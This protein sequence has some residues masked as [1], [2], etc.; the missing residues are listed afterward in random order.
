[1]CWSLQKNKTKTQ[2]DHFAD[3]EEGGSVLTKLFAA[4]TIICSGR[5]WPQSES[6]SRSGQEGLPNET[7][8]KVVFVRFKGYGNWGCSRWRE[9]EREKGNNIWIKEGEKSRNGCNYVPTFFSFYLNAGKKQCIN[10][11][12]KP[13]AG[14]GRGGKRRREADKEEVREIGRRK[15]KEG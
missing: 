12:C 6:T 10:L 1:M 15:R 8:P 9:R 5:S 11:S 7:R 2:V 14:R 13:Q 3:S 4:S